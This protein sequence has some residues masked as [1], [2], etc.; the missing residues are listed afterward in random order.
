MSGTRTP[1]GATPV[2]HLADLDPVGGAAVLCLRVWGDGSAAQTRLRREFD[3]SVGAASGTAAL[4]A[5][6]ELWAL[7]LAHGRRPLACHAAGCPLV[8]VD[9]GCF[10]HMIAAAA[11]GD[12]DEALLIA[13][14]IVRADVAPVVVALAEQLGL[15]LHRMALAERARPGPCGRLH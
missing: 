4:Q 15:A 1:R 5:L 11:C 9:E 12:R 10:A 6:D 13:C 3:R 14:N 7:C 2:A 8:G